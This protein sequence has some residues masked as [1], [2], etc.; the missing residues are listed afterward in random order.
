MDSPRRGETCV[1][2]DFL[3]IPSNPSCAFGG[4]FSKGLHF[5]GLSYIALLTIMVILIA[6]LTI[7]VILI[8]VPAVDG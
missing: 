8:A 4:A 1:A 2:G 6:L 5:Y 7:M 3:R